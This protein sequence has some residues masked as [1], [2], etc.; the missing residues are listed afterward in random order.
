MFIESNKIERR[1]NE[2]VGALANH[3]SF[4]REG[5]MVDGATEGGS[6]M[7]AWHV[8]PNGWDEV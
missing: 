4:K 5:K 7:L 1:V 8:E 2:A 6:K 3:K